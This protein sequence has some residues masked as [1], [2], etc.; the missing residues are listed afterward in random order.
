MLSSPSAQFFEYESLSAVLFIVGPDAK[1]LFLSTQR[2]QLHKKVPG[3]SH[4]GDITLHP[5]GV[6]K[7]STSFGWG[8]GGNVTSAGWKVTLCDPIWYVSSRSGDGRPDNTSP[9]CSLCVLANEPPLYVR[10]KRLSM[11]YSLKLS[12]TTQNPAYCGVFNGKFK[13]AFDRKPNQIPPLGIRVE[14]DLHAI[15]FKQKDIVESSISVTPSWLLDHPRVNRDLRCFHKEDIPPEIYRSRFHEI[16]S[17]YDGSHRLYMDGSKV[18]DQ[19]AS[20]A[21]TRLSLIHI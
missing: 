3:T 19:V 9:S 7:S 2:P 14:P 15:G 21:V 20:A 4:F 16:C 12:S 1:T 13:S 11:Q 10:Q 18:G 5:S 17:H 8:K 6:A